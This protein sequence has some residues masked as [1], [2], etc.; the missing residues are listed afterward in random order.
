VAYNNFFYLDAPPGGYGSESAPFSSGKVRVSARIF[1]NRPIRSR[2]RQIYEFF[3]NHTTL[4]NI[5]SDSMNDLDITYDLDNDDS[6]RGVTFKKLNYMYHTFLARRR[7][8]KD[9]SEDSVIDFQSVADTTESD[10]SFDAGYIN[11]VETQKTPGVPAIDSLDFYPKFYKKFTNSRTEAVHSCFYLNGSIYIEKDMGQYAFETRKGMRSFNESDWNKFADFF[12]SLDPDI[13]MIGL[14][15]SSQENKKKADSSEDETEGSR[16]LCFMSINCAYPGNFYKKAKDLKIL[17]EFVGG[18]AYIKGEPVS[19]IQPAY[20]F[21]PPGKHASFK[22]LTPIF[23]GEDFSIE[24]KKT[25]QDLSVCTTQPSTGGSVAYK[26]IN[27]LKFLDPYYVVPGWNP[28]APQMVPPNFGVAKFTLDEETN[29]LKMSNKVSDFSTEPYIIVEIDGGLNNMYFLVIAY[30]EPVRMY[31]VHDDPEILEQWNR[32]GG[33]GDHTDKRVIK[34]VEDGHSSLMYEFDFNGDTLLKE[35]DFKV[36]F[37]HINGALSVSFDKI[38]NPYIIHRERISKDFKTTDEELFPWEQYDGGTF[39]TFTFDNINISLDDFNAISW[40]YAPIKLRGY[41]HVHVGHHSCMFNFSPM[42]YVDSSSIEQTI[43]VPVLGFFEQRNSSSSGFSGSVGEDVTSVLLR[44]RGAPYDANEDNADVDSAGSPSG[45]FNGMIHGEENLYYKQQATIFDE[46]IDGSRFKYP[47]EKLP[48][49]QRALI[50]GVFDAEPESINNFEYG[51]LSKNSVLRVTKTENSLAGNQEGQYAFSY[52][53]AVELSSGDINLIYPYDSGDFGMKVGDTNWILKSSIRPICYGFSSFVSESEQPI[54][55]HGVKEVGHHVV[56]FSDNWSRNDRTFVNHDGTIKFYIS[57]G[58]TM[59]PLE[60]QGASHSPGSNCLP[61]SYADDSPSSFLNMTDCSI[62]I[63]AP[64]R[65]NFN[66]PPDESAFL[67]SLQDKTFYIRV[68]AWRDGSF[69]YGTSDN[70]EPNEYSKNHLLFTGL[71]EQ[72]SFDIYDSHIEMTCQLNDYNKILEDTLWFNS[73]YYDAMR[74]VNVIYDIFQQVGF[75]S[76]EHDG[77]FDPA[78]LIKKYSDLPT[79]S[80]Y[81]VIAHN[82]RCHLYNDYVL[83]GHYDPLQNPMFRFDTGSSFF[84]AV[85]RIAAISTKTAFFDRFGVFHFDVPEDEEELYNVD[86]AASSRT[87]DRPPVQASFWWSSDPEKANTSTPSGSAMCSD[88]SSFAMWNVITGEYNFKRIQSDTFNEI[89]IISTTPDMKLLIGNHMNEK[90]L[91]DPTSQGFRGYKKVFLQQSGYFGS[92]AAVEKTISN[93]TTMFT[94]PNYASFNVLGRSGLVPMNTV[95]LD[96]VGMSS[97]MR[98]VLVNVSN[99]I[100]AT[101]NEWI[102]SLEGRYFYPGQVVSF[103]GN[104]FPLKPA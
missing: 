67:S 4:K 103:E 5:K 26:M 93:Y 49:S 89:R 79:S 40:Q 10:G 84:D 33:V 25:S 43:A 64:E 38:K 63:G 30:N 73:P 91:Y 68:Y 46:I 81:S 50:P 78:S 23:P 82:G 55:E 98:L 95:M 71:C 69:F 8:V 60:S 2:N 3:F 75:F 47:A 6:S 18:T 65:S 17:D 80:E 45:D 96:G 44:S 83:P 66:Q 39:Y 62:P 37:Q 85:K 27:R 32:S 77:S 12:D 100:D 31:E 7:G 15:P 24:F 16:D 34:S 87:F 21:L 35:K 102:T 51:N 104:T 61:T 52:N 86:K 59:G 99:S 72:S 48:R 22:K 57:R 70:L 101:K 90:G 53:A 41:V 9:T 1:E 76:G 19:N 97:P 56:S 11:I 20:K 36:N 29:Q 54:Y 74:D 58:P 92:R 28:Y 14:A 42:K 94:P 13:G 88:D